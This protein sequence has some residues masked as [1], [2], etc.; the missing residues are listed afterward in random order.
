MQGLYGFIDQ[1]TV[2]SVK[3]NGRGQLSSTPIE[4][5]CR[6]CRQDPP[7]PD[8][9]HLKLIIDEQEH[10]A[11]LG[12]EALLAIQWERNLLEVRYKRECPP[13]TEGSDKLEQGGRELWVVARDFTAKLVDV[14]AL[15][16]TTK[17]DTTCLCTFC[18]GGES[19]PEVQHFKCFVTAGVTPFPPEFYLNIDWSTKRLQLVPKL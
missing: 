18:G 13:H 14:D 9:Q 15:L 4:C 6:F 2:L 3:P 11:L 19:R 10:D 7:E 5:Q 16:A 17:R 1:G 8:V 12:V